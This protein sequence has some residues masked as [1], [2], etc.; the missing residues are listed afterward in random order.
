MTTPVPNV[1]LDADG[2]VFPGDGT[3]GKETAHVHDP[4][5][6]RLKGRYFCFST[7]GN[8]FG[9]MRSSDD[10]QSWTVH[11]A[12]IPETPEWIRKRYS[13]R[14]LWAP[15]IV[16]FGD[17]VRMYYCASNFG[18]N[19]SVMG[20]LENK[21]FDPAEPQKGWVD[22]GM[23]LESTPGVSEYNAIDPEVVIDERGRHWM[24]FGSYWGGIYL[25][26][27]DPKTGK[28]LHP[29]RAPVCVAKNTGDRGNPLEAPAVL[30]HDGYYYLFVSYGLA[31]QG[32]RSTYRI[33]VGR[34]KDI[35]G[36]YVDADGK[37]MVEGG[38]VNVLKG[39]PPMFA[40]G[41]NDVFR[42]AEGRP[43]LAYHFYDGR[44]H[45]NGDNWGRPN[46]QIRELLWTK[47]GWPLPGLPI[48]TGRRSDAKGGAGFVGEWIHQADFGQPRPLTVK[49]DGTMEQ[50]ERRGTWKLENGEAVLE[51]TIE[52]RTFRDVL[53][54]AYGDSYYVGR[55]QAGSIIRGIRPGLG[56]K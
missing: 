46:L 20:F 29:D 27:L 17:T 38:H 47:D 12:V 36:P 37:S 4:T 39:S 21:A 5:I 32:V 16:Q 43:L 18:T 13:H 53:K 50:G 11:G 15:D 44:H 9:V 30:R 14:S 48:E 19:L 8:G 49:P 23:I 56:A 6:V 40:P 26:E 42:D 22:Q 34:S 7:S 55:N 2:A 1:Q 45:W 10:L 54:L 33:M 31:A 41:H 25:F 28:R 51:W 24:F 3:V 52:G 35:E